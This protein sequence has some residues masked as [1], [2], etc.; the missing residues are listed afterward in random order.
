MRSQTEQVSARRKPAMLRECPHST[1]WVVWTVL[2]M[3]AVLLFIAVVSFTPST[4]LAQAAGQE[5]AVGM[6]E[7]RG[8]PTPNQ[9]EFV[10]LLQ[11]TPQATDETR[12][13][14]PEGTPTNEPEPPEETGE[15]T[16]SHTSEPPEKTGEPEPTAE[17]TSE[18]GSTPEPVTTE[19]TSAPETTTATAT[20]TITATASPTPTPAVSNWSEGWPLGTIR[21]G[22]EEAG[23]PTEPIRI[24]I[25]EWLRLILALVVVSLVATFGARALYRLLRW[26]LARQQLPVDETLLVQLKPLLSW[27]LAAIM[28]HI[29]V[30][31]VNFENEPARELFADLVFFAYLGVATLTVWRL[32]DRA[33]DLYAARIAAEGHAKGE[34]QQEATIEKLHPL[35]LRWARTL[36]LLVSALVGLG[37]LQAGFSVPTI[38]VMLIGL[39]LILAARDTIADIVA[40]FAILLDQP[41]RVGDRIEVKGIDTWAEVVSIG[42]RTSVLRTRHNVEIIVPNSTIGKNQVINYSYPD[43]RYRMQTHVG[44]AFGTDVEHARRVMINAVRQADFV[45]PDEPVDALYVEIGDSDMIFRV[46]WWIDFHQD[47]ERSYDHVHTALHNALAQA[48]IESPYPS[49]SLNVEVDDQTLAE[50]WQAWQGEGEVGSTE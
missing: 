5:P 6:G 12:E 42:L 50:V 11:D 27:W 8:E 28:F 38:L 16:P 35:L 22:A 18:P 37:R 13:P 23:P 25:A 9:N 15:P 10:A 29:A 40:G 3:V 49:Q 46:R 30:R 44:I 39:T 47:W 2:L 32:V 21:F 26:A 36:I 24:T 7:R 17:E 34:A 45:L 33:I 19:P 41:F 14:T 20:A 31:W 1:G 4:A 48:G 43:P